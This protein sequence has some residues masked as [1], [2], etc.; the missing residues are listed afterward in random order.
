MIKYKRILIKLSGESL[1]DTNGYGFSPE[2]LMHYANEIKNAHEQGV[3]IAVV[4]G[5]GNI[6]RGIK[7]KNIN[8]DKTDGD[9]MGMLAT[10]I[11]SKALQSV[12]KNVGVDAELVCALEIEGI[13]RKTNHIVVE[14]ILKQNKVCIIAGGTGNPFFTTDSAAALRAIEMKADILLKGTRVD[15]VYSADPEKDPNA[16]PFESLTFGEVIDKELKIMDMTAFTL[17]REN[18]MPIVVFNIHKEGN[19]QKIIT[20]QNC[21]TLIN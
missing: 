4:L 2:M 1:A 19:I 7:S 21:G 15:A 5:G 12:L 18:N 8:I 9:Y 20:G 6:F 3:E 11:N 16:T 14:K 10:V 17:C 13:C